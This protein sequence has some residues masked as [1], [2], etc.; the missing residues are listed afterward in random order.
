MSAIV[1]VAQAPQQPTEGDDLAVNV[2]DHVYGAIE[3]R[4]HKTG[5]VHR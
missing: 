5:I 1:A 4:L 2:A 3:Q